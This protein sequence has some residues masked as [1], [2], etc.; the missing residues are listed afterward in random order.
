MQNFDGLS[1]IVMGMIIDK[2]KTRWGKARPWLLFMG[3]PLILPVLLVFFVPTAFSEDMKEVYIAVTYFLMSVICYTAVNL[4]YH[5]ML[6][7]FSLTSEDRSSVSAVRSVFSMMATLVVATI[8]PSIIGKFGGFNSQSA[9]TTT[10]LLYGIIAFV[11]I[12]ITFLKYIDSLKL[13][14]RTNKGWRMK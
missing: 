8:T 2:T 4:A 5:S 11:C 12:M 7:R 9:W 6:P 1:D 14:P 3:L 13:I 10:V